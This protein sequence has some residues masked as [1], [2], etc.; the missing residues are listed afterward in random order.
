MQ[1]MKYSIKNTMHKI[2]CIEY[3]A[4]KN[5]VHILQ[6]IEFTVQNTKRIMLKLLS[7]LGAI[8]RFFKSA[9]DTL[10]DFSKYRIYVSIYP[11]MY[12]SVSPHNRFSGSDPI[13]YSTGCSRWGLS[14]FVVYTDRSTVQMNTNLYRGWNKC[15]YN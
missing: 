10:A 15:S 1:C 3:T 14:V 6:C 2:Q 5:T 8:L 4:Q 13:V 9:R 11:C 7:Q 12:L